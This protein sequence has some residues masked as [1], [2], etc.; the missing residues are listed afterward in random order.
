MAKKKKSNKTEKNKRSIVKAYQGSNYLLSRMLIDEDD[1]DINWGIET[2]YAIATQVRQ[3]ADTIISRQDR[4]AEMHRRYNLDFEEGQ[5]DYIHQV[6]NNDLPVP[7]EFFPIIRPKVDQLTEEYMLRPEKRYATAVDD[8]STNQRMQE[9]FELEFRKFMKPIDDAMSE[10]VGFDVVP[11]NQSIPVVSNVERYINENP[12]DIDV[13]VINDTIEY[14][15]K[16]RKLKERIRPLLTDYLLSQHCVCEIVEDAGDPFIYRFRPDEYAYSM[17]ASEDF[18]DRANWFYGSKMESLGFV[19]DAFRKDLDEEDYAALEKLNEPSYAETFFKNH[20]VSNMHNYIRHENNQT[21][22]RVSRAYWQSYKIQKAKESYSK[23][24]KRMYF[25]MVGSDYEP[26][27]YERIHERMIDDPYQIFNIAGVFWIKF[28]KTENQSRSVDNWSRCPLPIVGLAGNNSTGF[29][30]SF[31][32]MLKP[33]EN[34]YNE[35]MYQIRYLIKNSGGKLIVYD[36]SQM[37]KQFGGDYGQ[38]VKEMKINQIVPVDLS[39]EGN[40]DHSNFNQWKELDFSLSNQITSLWNTKMAIEQMA[41]QI[42]GV[43]ENRSGN[44]SQY[45]TNEIANENIRRSSMRSETWLAPFDGF[46]VRVLE[47]LVA[48]AKHIWPEGKKLSY[49][50]GD[51]A[52][53]IFKITSTMIM[54]DWA[55]YLD[56]P[57]KKQREQEQLTMLAQNLMSSASAEDPRLLLQYVKVLKADS[58][59]EA[60]RVFEKGVEVIEQIR[61]ENQKSEQENQQQIAKMQQ[62]EANK[63]EAMK[64]EREELKRDIAEMNNTSRERIALILSDEA[65]IKARAELLKND[66][67]KE[68]STDAGDNSKPGEKKPADENKADNQKKALNS[69]KNNLI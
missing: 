24:K 56:N 65:E 34:L 20:Q 32:E 46:Y 57:F 37:P 68:G 60:E 12:I 16:V 41:G 27:S 66:L 50:K 61:K 42:S 39:Q 52:E 30:I 33:I 19:L 55:I 10:A 8:E 45:A 67:K 28:G 48:H 63:R 29:H 40:P 22:V 62:E 51:G 7:F 14:L 47:R 11:E 2:F 69:A 36:V 53:K 23:T 38:V 49:W 15:L 4:Y 44:I 43:D 64:S 58:Y 26:K 3:T 35:V 5:F 18:M 54:K 21:F 25:K 17:P 9:K 59:E 13:E 31:A 6:E 1:K